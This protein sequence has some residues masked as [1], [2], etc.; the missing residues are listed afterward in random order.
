LFD[1]VVCRQNGMFDNLA[2]VAQ[3]LR[4]DATAFDGW[5]PPVREVADR[6]DASGK[7]YSS[8]TDPTMLVELA[9]QAGVA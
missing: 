1:L 9:K 5:A 8:L 6:R 3:L 4:G 2:D 7:Y